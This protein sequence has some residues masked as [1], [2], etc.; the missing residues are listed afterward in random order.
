[1]ASGGVGSGIW[2]E[3]VRCES[4]LFPKSCEQDAGKRTGCTCRKVLLPVGSCGTVADIICRNRP[5]TLG[6]RARNERDPNISCRGLWRIQA[7]ADEHMY[8]DS[9]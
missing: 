1:M 9:R 6:T 4:Q 7:P 5:A 3:P 8:N 2:S